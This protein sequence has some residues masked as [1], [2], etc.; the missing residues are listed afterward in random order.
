MSKLLQ[1]SF[2]KQTRTVFSTEHGRICP[3]CNFRIDECICKQTKKIIANEFIHVYVEKKGRNGKSVT[4]IDGI[5][6]TSN[7]LKKILFDLKKKCGSGG[8]FKN[9]MIEIQGDQ[10][11]LIRKVLKEKGFKLK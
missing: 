3:E 10:V 11:D 4:V 7:D 2:P 9:Q 8:S 1:K 6:G 5:G